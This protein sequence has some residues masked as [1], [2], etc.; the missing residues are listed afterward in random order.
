MSKRSFASD[1]NAGV[2]SEIID[3]IKQ[4][5]DGHVLAYGSDPITARAL[6]LFQ[7]HFGSDVAVYFV[8]G[9]TGA[10]TLGLKAITQPHHAIFCADTA[11]VNV[12]E[13]RSEEH[14]SELQ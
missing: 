1:N 11:H 3:A 5:N 8:F 9:G 13:C 12:D 2:H 10:N 6:E 4:A 7:K 14:T